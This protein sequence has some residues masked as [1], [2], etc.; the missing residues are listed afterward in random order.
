[1]VLRLLY[2]YICLPVRSFQHNCRRN[3]YYIASARRIYTVEAVSLLQETMLTK[4]DRSALPTHQF[5]GLLVA[6]AGLF[7]M[8]GSSRAD[9]QS[10]AVLNPAMILCCG[11][12]LV[13]LKQEHWRDKKWFLASFALVFLLVVFYLAPL[14][15]QLDKFSQGAGEVAAIRAAAN[16][17]NASQTLAIAPAAVWQ[18]F[19]FLFA[20]LAVFLFAIQLNRDYLRLTLPIIILAGAISGII[21]VLQLADSANGPLYLYRITNN[22]SAVGLFAN[23]NHAAVF[24][25]C[26]FPMLAVFAARSLATNRGGWSIQRPLAI[27]V[28]IILIP[29]ILVTGSRSGMLVAIV[30]LIGSLLLYNLYVPTHGRPE[31]SKSLAPILAASVLA[32]LVFATIYFSRAEAIER[33]FSEPNRAID[34]ADFWTS[35]LKLFWHYFPFGF[36]PGSFVPAF[37]N[38]E[39]SAL[40]S[41][42][43]LNRL[44]NDWLETVLTFGANGILLLICGLAYYVRR[45]FLLWARMD[46]T[47][48]AV[49]MGRMASVIIAIFAI[50]SMSDYPLRTPAMM[51]LAALVLVW[52]AEADREPK[53]IAGN[54][55]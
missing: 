28:A 53:V 43:Y 44:H 15:S 10:L 24:L 31:K 22:G 13:T 51:G 50:A 29:L 23:R 42:T 8:G 6:L 17:P 48:T 36:G 25:A 39:P 5:W 54:S 16:A 41:S 19:F 32:C 20:P 9:V 46:G 11:V 49:A 52:F 3:G 14:P 45:S 7:S 33:I 4:I 55:A 37:Q 27:A 38:E 21:G 18:P 35:S 1:M 34:R 12:A 26:L 47:C 40:L 2:T 30:G